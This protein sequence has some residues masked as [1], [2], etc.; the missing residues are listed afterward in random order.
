M[1]QKSRTNPFLPPP[2]PPFT[3]VIPYSFKKE[4]EQCSDNAI[5]QC[6]PQFMKKVFV[7]HAFLMTFGCGSF[8]SLGSHSKKNHFIDKML[9]EKTVYDTALDIVEL[10]TIRT[11]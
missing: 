10:L 6:F 4:L 5:K 1:H 3:P 2:L 8:F 11:Q 9:V 7:D